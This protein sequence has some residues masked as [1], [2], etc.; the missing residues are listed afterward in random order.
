MYPSQ[1]TLRRLADDCLGLFDACL[2]IPGLSATLVAWFEESQAH[3]RWWSFSLGAQR[4]GRASLDFRVRH[5]DRIRGIIT[6]HL[7]AL[8]SDL[9]QCL[10]SVQSTNRRRSDDDDDG[11]PSDE[12]SSLSSGSEGA[13]ESDTEQHAPPPIRYVAQKN[14]IK[15]T[16][17]HLIHVSVLIRKS[18]DRFRHA[19]ADQDLKRV[20]RESPN[21][22]AAFKTHLETVIL[23]GPSEY[24]LLS[25]LNS[26]VRRDAI[27]TGVRAIL[28]SWLHNRLGPIQQRLVEANVIRRHR[29]ML[30]RKEGRPDTTLPA[31]SQSLHRQ[32]VLPRATTAIQ[33]PVETHDFSPPVAEMPPPSVLPVRPMAGASAIQTATAIGPALDLRTAR[34]A[35]ASSTMSRLTRTGENQDY[36]KRSVLQESPVCPYC[37]VLL[38][39]ERSR[40]EKWQG[41]VAHDL[42]PYT[43]IFNDCKEP[44]KLYSTREQWTAH[45]RSDHSATHW[46][47]SDCLVHV[48]AGNDLAPYFDSESDCREHL[49]SHHGDSLSPEELALKVKLSGRSTISPVSCPLCL[50]DGNRVDVEDDDHI[51]SHLHS[52]S[53]RALPWDHNLDDGLASAGSSDSSPTPGLPPISFDEDFDAVDY[54]SAVHDVMKLVQ[55]G[56]A[57]YEQ[58]LTWKQELGQESLTRLDDMLPGLLVVTELSSN[59]KD[60]CSSLL[61]RLR[62]NLGQLSLGLIQDT[63]Q[64]EDLCSNIILDIG[65]LEECISETP[66]RDHD[67]WQE[68][69]QGLP[70]ESKHAVDR[71]I[72]RNTLNFDTLPAQLDR[73][74]TLGWII[75][76]T[77]STY[78]DAGRECA[79]GIARS[80]QQIGDDESIFL[81]PYTDVP[82]AVIQAAMEL[83][84][85]EPLPDKQGAGPILWVLDL[86]LRAVNRGRLLGLTYTLEN[87]P[88]EAYAGLRFAMLKFYAAVLEILRVSVLSGHFDNTSDISQA[89][90]NPK[91]ARG[92]VRILFRLSDNVDDAVHECAEMQTGT[93][94]PE[95]VSLL[96]D[97]PLIHQKDGEQDDYEDYVEDEDEQLDRLEWVSPDYSEHHENLRAAQTPNTCEWVLQHEVFRIWEQSG[98]S[99]VLWLRGSAGTGKSIISSRVVDHIKVRT[100]DPTSIEGFA[101]FYCRA[102]TG[103]RA[104]ESLVRSLVRQLVPISTG[105][106][107]KDVTRLLQLLDEGRFGASRPNLNSWAEWLSEAIDTHHRTTLVIDGLDNLEP[108]D[109]SFVVNSLRNV[110]QFLTHPL[111]ILISSRENRGI[112]RFVES[113]T[114]RHSIVLP[115]WAKGGRITEADGAPPHTYFDIEEVIRENWIN[116]PS[117]IC[118]QIAWESEGS[119]LWAKAAAHESRQPPTNTIVMGEIYSSATAEFE[120]MADRRKAV[121][122]AALMWISCACQPL[123]QQELV[124]ISCLDSQ[125]GSLHAMP[126]PID[127]KDLRD[128][129]PSVLVLDTNVGLGTDVWRLTHSSVAHYFSAPHAIGWSLA[130]AHTEAAKLCLLLLLEARWEDDSS[131]RDGRV[132][133]TAHPLQFYARNHWVR[134][135]KAVEEEAGPAADPFLIRLLKQFLGS[136]SSSSPQYRS[137][138][139][140][141]LLDA[142]SGQRFLSQY[143]LDQDSL[144]FIAPEIQSLFA[145]ARFSLF[146]LL[147]DW[148][149]DQERIHLRLLNSDDKALLQVVEDGRDESIST[150]RKLVELGAD[151]D[152]SMNNEYGNAATHAAALGNLDWL[153]FLLSKGANIGQTRS[154][155]FGSPMIA[156]AYY[157]NTDTV[158][159]L[160]DHGAA[161]NFSHTTTSKGEFINPPLAAAIRGHAAALQILVDNGVR[162]G[163]LGGLYLTKTAA[164]GN[165]ECLQIFIKAGADVNQC[166]LTEPYGSPLAAAARGGHLDCVEALLDAGARVNEPF[167]EFSGSALCDAASEG[168][169]DCVHVLL[170]A[171]ADVNQQN[172]PDCTF[173]N[174]LQAV[175]SKGGPDC[176]RVIIEAGVDVNQVFS[177]RPLG[178]TALA[179]SAFCGQFE[180]LRALIEYGAYVNLPQSQ[181][182]SEPF[183]SALVAAICG[184]NLVCVETL[185]EAGADVNIPLRRGIFGSPLAAAAGQ[186]RPNCLKTL[187]KAG[188]RVNERL[189]AGEFGSAL[190]VAAWFGDPR[191]IDALVQA[192]ADPNLQPEPGAKTRFGS[193]LAAAAA[194]CERSCVTQLVEAGA[195]LNAA[196][197]YGSYKTPLRAAEVGLPDNEE[198][199]QFV[200]EFRGQGVI[201]RAYT[202]SSTRRDL[203]EAMRRMGAREG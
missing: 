87:T 164:T 181:S 29:M 2:Q 139:Q 144:D 66:K 132:W 140:Q 162:L 91:H 44:Y 133:N 98:Q 171:G 150:G 77:Y 196:L 24:C 127:Q 125:E 42:N 151:V 9:K 25:L 197:D 178:S 130:R 69:L 32:A 118:S 169:V 201:M 18:G 67:L 26:A 94:D 16:L 40:E 70:E 45:L 191:S 22:Y 20:E 166:Y 168:H 115:H 6:S 153:R 50:N 34:S 155:R 33:R 28:R 95:I 186:S 53:L 159:L 61:G 85:P 106:P 184:K 3:L 109:L 202:W 174:A 152:T 14:S 134:H 176:L 157:G 41:H 13:N 48:G 7:L 35:R 111:R 101:F 79:E 183:E 71:L 107:P 198:Y 51:A 113:T 136:P 100:E 110:L 47:C 96:E 175:A 105:R 31:G 137:W 10:V 60:K 5:H 86:A 190:A 23:F 54:E 49:I 55:H 11:F 112:R 203:V 92:A 142:K 167:P 122:R 93:V 116:I 145:M 177:P 89:M 15:A 59:Q 172:G 4:P 83:I 63:N 173:S 117:D 123:T 17:H 36:P 52:F 12:S 194:M 99:A 154:G 180:T 120:A 27:P 19:R 121:A 131:P 138:Y 114:E 56:A 143:P 188:A 90:V 170:Q 126:L 161:V 37:G 72:A 147:E 8:I 74:L 68:A 75:Q 82:W 78:G 146:G 103:P 129:W 163:S 141:V 97:L 135:V 200:A 158:K 165:L 64:I 80:L 39:K 128:L 84:A 46:Y 104:A 193:P 185:I 30:S 148:W 179:T 76:D 57:H 108:S 58:N 160:I 149:G 156:A 65:A 195:D 119:F 192:G 43:C 124:E 1:K 189:S 62:E 102:T 182:E 38:D 88:E 199:R 81:T 21:T 187:V 73:L